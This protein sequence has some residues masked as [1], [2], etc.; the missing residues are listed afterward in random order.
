MSSTELKP[1][2][3]RS[4]S[5]DLQVPADRIEEQVG[6]YDGAPAKTRAFLQMIAA[7]PDVKK[8]GPGIGGAH[9]LKRPC[10]GQH[11]LPHIPEAVGRDYVDVDSE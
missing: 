9:D 10:L 3:P 1:D 11:W 8:I 5:K 6:G 7:V 4:F 2:L